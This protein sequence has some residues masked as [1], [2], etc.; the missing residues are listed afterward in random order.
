ML[1][2][3]D[4]SIALIT[5]TGCALGISAFAL[6]IIFDISIKNIIDIFGVLAAWGILGI[7]YKALSIWNEVVDKMKASSDKLNKEKE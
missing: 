3:Y 5:A 1:N 2:Q 7:A 6:A 4:E